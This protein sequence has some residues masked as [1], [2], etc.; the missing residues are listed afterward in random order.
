MVKMQVRSYAL[1][2]W[3]VPVAFLAALALIP[4]ALM[5][6]LGL[7]AVA[8]GTSV[9][10]ALLPPAKAPQDRRPFGETGRLKGDAGSRPAIDAD[11]EVKDENAKN[12]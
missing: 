3:V 7:A 11:Y 1:P 12:E 5:L 2:S 4:F 8:I 6:A 9:V 10:F